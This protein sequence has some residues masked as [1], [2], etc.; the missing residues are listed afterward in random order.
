MWEE[1]H[2]KV[3]YLLHLSLLR[4]LDSHGP[5]QEGKSLVVQ[6]RYD[7]L[8][9]ARSVSSLSIIHSLR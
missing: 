8:K 9:N 6:I 4:D 1:E 5:H 7:L 2:Y 3:K